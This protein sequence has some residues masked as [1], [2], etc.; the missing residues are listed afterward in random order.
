MDAVILDPAPI[1]HR[2][3]ERRAQSRNAVGGYSHLADDPLKTAAEIMASKF[4]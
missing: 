4:K 3:F 1:V 2:G